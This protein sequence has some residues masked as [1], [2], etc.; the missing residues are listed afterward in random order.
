MDQREITQLNKRLTRYTKK[1]LFQ[2]KNVYVYGGDEALKAMRSCLAELDIPVVGML[3]RQRR[4]KRYLMGMPSI[5]VEDALLPFRDDNIVLILSKRYYMEITHWLVHAGYVQ[6]G[7]SLF[8]MTCFW[9]RRMPGFP[10]F[11][12]WL[13]ESS[14]GTDPITDWQEIQ[15]KPYSSRPILGPETYI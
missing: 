14:E 6:T 3:E 8:S 15:E 1:G 10:P 11:A 4:A 5:V 9:Q 7:I 13:P 12:L 2:N